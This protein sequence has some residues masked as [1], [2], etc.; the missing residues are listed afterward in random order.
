MIRFQMI[1]VFLEDVADALYSMVRLTLHWL[2]WK[3]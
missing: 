2:G 1:M 3:R